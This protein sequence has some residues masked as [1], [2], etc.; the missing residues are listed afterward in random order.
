MQGVSSGNG[1]S[2]GGLIQQH[3]QGIPAGALKVFRNE[4]GICR[5]QTRLIKR[6][7]VI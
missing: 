2:L 1:H 5:T 7:I 6:R 4:Y 3:R